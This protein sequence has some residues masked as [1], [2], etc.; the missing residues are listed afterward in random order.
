M[1]RRIQARRGILRGVSPPLNC[2]LSWRTAV[3]IVAAATMPAAADADPHRLGVQPL[4]GG[5]DIRQELREPLRPSTCRRCSC[6]TEACC[7]AEAR[8]EQ[9]RIN[10][11]DRSDRL[12]H[13]KARTNVSS[14]ANRTQVV[15]ARSDLGGHDAVSDRG[16]DRNLDH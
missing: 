6:R 16:S 8:D 7:W 15:Y 11:N 14:C 12:K 4:D 5:Q 1:A 13:R 9:L 2:M 10:R 3:N